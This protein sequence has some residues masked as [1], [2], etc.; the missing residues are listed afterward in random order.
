MVVNNLLEGL[1]CQ[2]DVVIKED[3]RSPVQLL[4]AKFTLPWVCNSQGCL[5]LIVQNV[6][7]SPESSEQTEF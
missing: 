6:S 4:G 3:H 5:R 1:S 2:N 7:L